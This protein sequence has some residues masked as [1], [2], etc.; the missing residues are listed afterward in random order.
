VS[1][2]RDR[3]KHG[4]DRVLEGADEFEDTLLRCLKILYEGAHE[5]QGFGLGRAG[6]KMRDWDGAK[7]IG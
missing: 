4:R 7:N 6:A 3:V 5:L 1:Q 2:G